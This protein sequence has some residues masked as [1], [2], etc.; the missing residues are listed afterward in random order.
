MSNVY[1]MGYIKNIQ[2]G[3]SFVLYSKKEDKKKEKN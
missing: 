2:N 3:T 1:H